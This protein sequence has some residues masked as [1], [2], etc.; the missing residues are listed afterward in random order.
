[1]DCTLKYSIQVDSKS[2]S[3]QKGLLWQ[4]SPADSTEQEKPHL[5]QP[6]THA[7]ERQ[8][9][10]RTQ[11]A[12]LASFPVH[13]TCS[14]SF[15]AER[16]R[17]KG[18]DSF[19]LGKSLQPARLWFLIASKADDFHESLRNNAAVASPAGGVAHREATVWTRPPVALHLG[20]RTNWCGFGHRPLQ[21]SRIRTWD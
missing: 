17:E 20:S 3:H 4:S 8:P 18:R 7:P 12:C 13:E 2:D 10:V 15:H 16:K 19:R 5:G 6:I 14:L 9:S 21:S 1:M 11:P